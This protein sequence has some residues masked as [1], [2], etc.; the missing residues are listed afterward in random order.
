[1]L[2]LI[3][4]HMHYFCTTVALYP[5]ALHCYVAQCTLGSQRSVAGANS[6]RRRFFLICSAVQCRFWSEE[7]CQSGEKEFFSRLL[8]FA[9]LGSLG[10][11]QWVVIVII[12]IAIVIF[13]VIVIVIV[14]SCFIFWIFCETEEILG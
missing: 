12:A 4:L 3:I 2:Y 8:I 7:M 14:F 6:G 5:T 1:M 10:T 9:G 11:T 13:F